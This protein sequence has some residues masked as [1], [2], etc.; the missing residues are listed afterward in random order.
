MSFLKWDSHGQ[1]G[2]PSHLVNAASDSLVTYISSG[3]WAL[4]VFVL[5][6]VGL[7][8]VLCLFC[9]FAFGGGD[10]YGNAQKGKKGVRRSGSWSGRDVESGKGRFRSA[11]ELG[12]KAGGRVVG[13][14]KRD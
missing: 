5:A 3:A 10:E 7:F 11:E 1:V 8:V 9:I 4:F 14:G 13:V 12:L 6:I 2:T